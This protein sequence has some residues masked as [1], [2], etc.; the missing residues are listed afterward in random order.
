MVEW[1]T[2]SRMEDRTGWRA[3][4]DNEGV[5]FEGLSPV[6]AAILHGEGRGG[7]QKDREPWSSPWKPN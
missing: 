7:A 4:S 1:N 5:N 6:E 3:L 2:P